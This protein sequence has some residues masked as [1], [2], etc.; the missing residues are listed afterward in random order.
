MAEPTEEQKAAFRAVID[1]AF[2]HFYAGRRI[3]MAELRLAMPQVYELV[4]S[5]FRNGVVEGYKRGTEA[6]I[7]NMTERLLER[8]PQ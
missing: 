7:K 3:Q 8:I 6:G 2:D 1:D 4:E 5:A